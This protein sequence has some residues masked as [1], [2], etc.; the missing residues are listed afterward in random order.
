MVCVCFG[1]RLHLRPR[2]RAAMKPIVRIGSRKRLGYV[3][4]FRTDSVEIAFR[5]RVRF[6]SNPPQGFASLLA[7]RVDQIS[8]GGHQ[9]VILLQFRHGTN[10]QKSRRRPP[11]IDLIDHPGCVRLDLCVS[12]GQDLERLRKIAFAP[13]EQMHFENVYEAC[14]VS[15]DFQRCE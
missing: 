6:S 10:H 15:P 5:S 12:V 13:W 1:V 9:V 4:H 14:R 2:L 8:V 3:R 11:G 7:F